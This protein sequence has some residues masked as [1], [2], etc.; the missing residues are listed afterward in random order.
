MVQ[1]RFAGRV[2]LVTGAASGIGRAIALQ[3]AAEGA[4]VSLVDINLEGAEAVAKEVE[5]SNGIAK[6]KGT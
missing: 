6:W 4:M 1:E 5:A 2:A 3:F